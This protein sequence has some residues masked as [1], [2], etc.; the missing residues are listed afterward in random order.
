MGIGL[1]GSYVK[2]KNP[3]GTKKNRL[4]PHTGASG[5]TKLLLA[6]VKSPLRLYVSVTVGLA[7]SYAAASVG[8]A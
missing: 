2:R 1:Q 4:P 8:K 5:Q 3:K 6:M 7:G